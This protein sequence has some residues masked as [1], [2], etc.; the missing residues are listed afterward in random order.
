M[1]AEDAPLKTTYYPP[2]CHK[3]AP[4][5][6][7]WVKLGAADVHRLTQPKEFAGQ[8]IYF[9][10][11]H[12]IQYLCLAGVIVSRDEQARRTILV[13]DDSTGFTIEVVC[14]K[15]PPPL[16]PRPQTAAVSLTPT[17]AQTLTPSSSIHNGANSLPITHIAST[18]RTPLDINP[19][20]AGSVAK[21]KGTI[22]RFRGM[23]QLH[24][25]RYTLLRET[26][27]EVRFWEEKMRFFVEV[28]CVPWVLSVEE[29][30]RLRWED[31][32]EEEMKR[33]KKVVREARRERRERKMVEREERDRLRIERRYARE[34]VLRTKYG[35]RCRAENRAF[36]DE[37]RRR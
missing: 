32:R 3:A 6:F 12:P 14:S 10:N 26:S 36:R 2:Y 33:R 15:P 4:T 11:N 18:T 9:Y 17:T 21:L 29:R 13:L 24:L 20:R 22:T 19:L 30:E 8:N 25:E 1:A 16:Q 5:Y 34:E 35:E 23:L 31:V 7:T 37:K 27:A 28:L